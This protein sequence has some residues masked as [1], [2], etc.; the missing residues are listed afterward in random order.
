[1]T[2]PCILSFTVYNKLQIR[3]VIT[4]LTDCEMGN[5]ELTNCRA[6]IQTSDRLKTV[7]YGMQYDSTV[8]RSVFCKKDKERRNMFGGGVGEGGASAGPCRGIPS[9]PPPPG[10]SHVMTV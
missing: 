2:L 5:E 1:M 7:W 6:E 9:P 3:A 4:H 8:L 10:T